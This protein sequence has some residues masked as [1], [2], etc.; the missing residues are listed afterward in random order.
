MVSDQGLKFGDRCSPG[1]LTFPKAVPRPIKVGQLDPALG[2]LINVIGNVGVG[3][4]KCL[5]LGQ[6]IELKLFGL[7]S[8]AELIE[9]SRKDLL[10]ISELDFRCELFGKRSSGL[11]RSGDRCA[12]LNF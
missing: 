5:A 1:V 6:A 10:Y 11:R 4:D 12:V 2:S 9:F 3:S 8:A 7:V